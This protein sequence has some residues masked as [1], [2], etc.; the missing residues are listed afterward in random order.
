MDWLRIVLDGIAMSLVFNAVAGL[1]VFLKPHAYA[2]M[3]PKEIKKAAEPYTK[4][5]LAGLAAIIYPLILGIILWMILSAHN[6]GTEGFWNLFWT[7]YV[8]ML[9]VNFGDFFFLDCWLRT[10]VRDRC[11]IPET[12]GCKAWDVKEYMKQAAPEHFL[13]W[14]LVICP[15]VSLVCAGV[16]SY[17]L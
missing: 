9:F 10:V 8:E 5:E 4:K 11:L 15:L 12:K 2:H 6:S 1:G 17:I 14:P 16:G 7:A 3:L 13:A